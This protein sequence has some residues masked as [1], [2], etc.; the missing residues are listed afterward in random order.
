MHRTL[1]PAP[2]GEGVFFMAQGRLPLP[3]NVGIRPERMEAVPW[4]ALAVEPLL[5]LY[6][7]CGKRRCRSRLRSQAG[8][9]R[10]HRPVERISRDS[11]LA[12]RHSPFAIRHSPQRLRG[13]SRCSALDFDCGSHPDRPAMVASR[14]LRK[15]LGLA[16][17]RDFVDSNA[18]A[19]EASGCQASTPVSMPGVMVCG[20][21]AS[22]C[23]GLGVSA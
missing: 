3:L 5:V 18:K 22:R 15:A 1:F 2:S 21:A 8:A 9:S 14:I 19:V 20:C 17:T 7:G 23:R 6:G 10:R 11:P 12:N 4:L 16:G 13:G